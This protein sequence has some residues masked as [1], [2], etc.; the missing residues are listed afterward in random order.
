MAKYPDNLEGFYKSADQKYNFQ[1]I[2]PEE[3][4]AS[5]MPETVDDQRGIGSAPK[6]KGSLQAR[7]DDMLV[8]L[9]AISVRTESRGSEF[10]W[11]FV[12]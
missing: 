8:K 2:A 11:S 1:A 3:A 10:H 4:A 9:G 12:C 5:N 7:L 6:P